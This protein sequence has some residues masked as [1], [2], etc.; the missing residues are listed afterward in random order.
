MEEVNNKSCKHTGVAVALFTAW[1]I[2]TMLLWLLAFYRAPDS[3][4]QWLLR[5]QLVCFGTSESGLPDTYG[6]LI[7]ILAPLSFIAS[8][9]VVLGREF[10]EG[11]NAVASKVPGALC[12]FILLSLL[13]WESVW[14]TG[15]IKRGLE[16]AHA[17]YSITSTKKF[18]SDYP[19]TDK[20]LPEFKLVNQNSK[21]VSPAALKGKL[22]FLTFAFAHCQTICPAIIQNSK[23]ALAAF[24]DEEA[25][26]VIITLDPR[27]D[28]PSSLPTLA[29]NW[30][31]TSNSQV[32]SG[33]IEEVEKTI[34]LFNV[35][36]ERDEKTGDVTHPAMVYVL[37][38]NGQI[39]Y[40]F[41]NPYTDWLIE[42]GNR[43]QQGSGLS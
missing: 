4:P 9:A 24:P 23:A 13:T 10:I 6:W 38:P 18:P 43:V 40:T 5:A 2:V 28:T 41:N 21:Q 12:I 32:L 8:L 39:A 30:E 26:L 19:R 37:D 27:R 34:A 25:E 31:L 22:V 35:P 16:I 14:A 3:T 33:E 29:K 1:L 17:D 42:A 11:I 20:P 36:I 7:L 15:Q